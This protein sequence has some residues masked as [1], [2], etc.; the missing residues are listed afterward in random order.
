MGNLLPWDQLYKNY[1]SRVQWGNSILY[2][3]ETITVVSTHLDQITHILNDTVNMTKGKKY[4]NVFKM[5]TS[6]LTEGNT[7]VPPL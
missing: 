3:H 5:E 6:L 4:M 1:L 7:T 2:T